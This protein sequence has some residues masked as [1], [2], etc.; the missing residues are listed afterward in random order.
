MIP[1]N[2]QP[3]D[4]RIMVHETLGEVISTLKHMKDPDAYEIIRM[5]VQNRRQEAIAACLGIT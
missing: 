3:A 2:D 5:V 4:E 1:S